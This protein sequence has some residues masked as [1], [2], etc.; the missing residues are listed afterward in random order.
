MGIF[1][2]AIRAH[3]MNVHERTPETGYLGV[4]HEWWFDLYLKLCEYISQRFNLKD[5]VSME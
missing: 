5:S 3:H 2:D 1:W 4:H